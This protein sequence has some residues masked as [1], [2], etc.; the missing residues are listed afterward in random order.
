M[1]A[2]F[3]V[4]GLKELEAAL[5]KLEKQ[6]S[7]KTVLRNA[8]KAA[9][10]A[11]AGVMSSMAPIDQGDLSDS[12]L[13]S[14]KV[15]SEV[16]AVAYARTMRATYGDKAAATKSMRDARRAAKGSA[17]PFV[18]FVGPN[19]NAFYAKFVEFGTSPFI[20][21]GKF[22]GAQNPG[23]QAQPFVRPAW[24]A[25]QAEALQ[26]IA[27]EMRVQIDKAIIRQNKRA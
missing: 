5:M 13:V 22:A 11:V 7:R 19:S 16:G 20:S 12:I 27:R 1:K 3:K 14:Q 15:K 9:G 25:T 21:G 24:D 10:N 4:E 18:M 8:T 23:V 2:S 6:A 26:I 17:P